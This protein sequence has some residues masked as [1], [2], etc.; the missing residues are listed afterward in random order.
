MSLRVASFGLLTTVQDLGRRGFQHLGVGPGGAMDEASHRIA[1]LLLGNPNHAPT[2]EITLSGPSL[3]FETES[4]ITLCGA[5]LSPRIADQ[6]MPLWRPVMVAAG[7]LLSFGRPVQGA[8]CYLGVEG[9]FQVPRVMGSAST[10]LSAGFGGFQGRPLKIGDRLET[11]PCPKV[12][13]PSLRQ[14][15]H[16]GQHLLLGPDWFVPWYQFLEF[17]QPAMLRF[18]PGSQWSGLTGPSRQC[19]LASPF[20]VAA[21]SNRMGIRLLGPKLSLEQPQEMVS[22]GVAMGTLQ[23]PSDGSIILLMADRQTTGG[24]PRLGEVVSVDLPRAAQL[25]PGEALR[26]S[27]VSVEEAQDLFLSREKRFHDLELVL[28]DQQTL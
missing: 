4:M 15:F 11:G 9:G 23:L 28:A 17:A 19:L 5:D 10:H 21:H 18:I 7:S 24:Y 16:Q 27:Q 6:R 13:Y 26:L 25:R 14:R 3:Y 22:S 1:N 12:R 20:E 8:R 2:L